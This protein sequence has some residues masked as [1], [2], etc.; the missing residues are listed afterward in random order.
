MNAGA[1]GIIGKGWVRGYVR[2]I[3]MP[4]WSARNCDIVI[5]GSTMINNNI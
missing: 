3:H 2:D 5:H 1:G 4:T